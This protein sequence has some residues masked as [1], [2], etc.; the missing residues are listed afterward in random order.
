M[1]TLRISL[2]LAALLAAGACGGSFSGADDPDLDAAVT[3]LVRTDT[4]AQPPEE[5]APP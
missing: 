1:M 2:S 4:V 5:A 3:D